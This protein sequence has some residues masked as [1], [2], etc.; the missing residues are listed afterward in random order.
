MI[1]ALLEE[2]QELFAE[3][4]LPCSAVLA[5]LHVRVFSHLGTLRGPELKSST[6]CD[7]GGLS[8]VSVTLKETNP[9]PQWVQHRSLAYS[10][11]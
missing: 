7:S 10:V 8:C 11:A 6:A 9:P 2:S 4:R 1:C 5:L 3:C